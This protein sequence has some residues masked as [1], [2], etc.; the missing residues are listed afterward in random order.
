M[1]EAK[2]YPGPAAAV[3]NSDDIFAQLI[4]EKYE[5]TVLHKLQLK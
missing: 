4:K 2:T 5:G 1:A 3:A